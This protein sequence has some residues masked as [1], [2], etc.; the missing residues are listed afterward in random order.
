MGLRRRGSASPSSNM[1]IYN[2]AENSVKVDRDR[3]HWGVHTTSIKF[4]RI[5][6][7][8]LE[9]RNQELKELD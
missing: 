6:G 9:P 1:V 2:S 3:Q 8:E 4:Y 5:F 7:R